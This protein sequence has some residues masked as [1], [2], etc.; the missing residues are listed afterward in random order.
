MKDSELP[1]RIRVRVGENRFTLFK[2]NHQ[3]EYSPDFALFSI[4]Y[5]VAERVGFPVEA[6][7]KI[8][9]E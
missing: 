2:R 4:S 5:K 3:H 7:I 9:G 6:Y 8:D 1:L